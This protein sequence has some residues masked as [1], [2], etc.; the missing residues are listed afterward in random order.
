MK[1]TVANL[2]DIRI[3][4]NDTEPVGLCGYRK[5]TAW[6]SMWYELN[7]LP[8]KTSPN[9]FDSGIT[10]A[11]GF[12]YLLFSYVPITHVSDDQPETF[13]QPAEFVRIR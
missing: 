10:F 8:G 12:G 2:E 13:N 5:T 9:S 6:D 4:F 11:V 1:K 7:F 3:I